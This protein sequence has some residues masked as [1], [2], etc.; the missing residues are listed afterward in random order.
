MV[1]SKRN[2]R[3]EVFLFSENFKTTYLEEHIQTD[4]WMNQK[5]CVYKIYSQES[6]SEDVLFRAVAD[7]QLL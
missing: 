7:T 5:N 1:L 2:S 6:T 3:A 4:A